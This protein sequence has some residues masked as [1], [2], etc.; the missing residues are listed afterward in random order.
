MVLKKGIWMAMIAALL[1][2]VV[3]S[4]VLAGDRNFS[5]RQSH[6]RGF[7]A[8][9]GLT[10]EQ[11]SK[12]LE[13]QQK[14]EQETLALRQELQ[15]KRLELKHLWNEEKPQESK[16][17]SLMKDMVPAQ[18]QL[19]LKARSLQEEI[20]KVLT[21]EQLKKYEQRGQKQGGGRGFG[22]HSIKYRGKNISK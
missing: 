21:P 6:R 19:R 16:I 11:Q 8:K 7:M 18:V 9:L 10:A 15:K 12:I 14:H 4:T 20:K 17:V 13:V 2:A 5:R 3:G 22:Q 1:V